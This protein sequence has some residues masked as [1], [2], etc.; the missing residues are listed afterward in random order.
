MGE[1]HMIETLMIARAADTQRFGT[2]LVNKSNRRNA[3]FECPLASEWVNTINNDDS[4]ICAT[5][6]DEYKTQLQEWEARGEDG[7]K[8]PSQTH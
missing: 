1:H 2:S 8:P 6:A 3:R 5:M 4:S 7:D